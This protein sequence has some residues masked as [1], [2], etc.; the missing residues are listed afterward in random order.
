MTAST[1]SDV[2]D[3]DVDD[4]DD[5]D[6]YDEFA[7]D[8]VAQE[9]DP[10]NVNRRNSSILR[11]S[12]FRR[13]GSKRV[14]V[15]GSIS[16]SRHSSMGTIGEMSSGETVPLTNSSSHS[17]DV[18]RPSGRRGMKKPGLG[19]NDT[20]HSMRAWTQSF[21][22]GGGK[23]NTAGEGGDRR[24]ALSK[25]YAANS[26][27]RSTRSV[28]TVDMEWE[29]DPLWK[30]LLRYIRILPPH[31]DE[32]P[33][34]RKIRI[35]TWICLLLDLLTG[36]VSI[37]TY[38]GVTYC[39]GE[40]ILSIAGNFNWNVAI[41][42]T[43]WLYMVMIFAEILPVMRETFPFNLANPFVGFLITFAKFFDD[44]ILEA[45]IMWIIEATA[46]LCEFWVYR[47][48]VQW[49]SQRGER[50]KQT[51][52]ALE[53]VRKARKRRKLSTSTHST[54]SN[55]S[56][57]GGSDVSSI[58]DASF[59]D[60]SEM[61]DAESCMAAT[62]NTT[63]IR[64]NDVSQIRETRLLR[65]RRLLRQAQ[66]EDRRHLKFHF[67][68]V[69]FNI[70]LVCISLLMVIM[71]GRSGGL[72]IVDMIPPNIFKTGQLEKCFD[73]KG[74]NGVCEVCRDDGTSHCYYPYY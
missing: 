22:W 50:L 38:D 47:L 62:I 35:L 49:H 27:S 71:I 3:L 64:Q 10:E 30:Q 45:V 12:N 59:H 58:G 6:D 53:K 67:A 26:A 74:V 5:D 43:V 24:A 32:K 51:E 17:K 8:T 25:D 21:K 13:A 39:C 72:C 18:V 55:L 65:E 15:D 2:D 73:C 68:G 28:L 23:K 63:G 14:G 46:V 56:S 60:E 29:E 41:R 19:L 69:A 36:I 61:N 4:D 57:G 66:K 44:R 7:E 11:N 52:V 40:P 16:V 54:G 1:A 31:A 70:G 48:K 20:E 42:V 34:K 9:D 37:T 33:I